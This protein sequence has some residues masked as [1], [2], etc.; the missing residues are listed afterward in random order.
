MKGEAQAVGPVKPMPPHG[1]HCGTVPLGGEVGWTTT[2]EE[3]GPPGTLA[4]LEGAGDELPVL[5]NVEPMS[6]HLMF[7]KTTLAFG[8]CDSTWA[9]TPEVVGQV[10]RATP[11]R[12]GSLSVG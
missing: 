7:E 9:G 1:P 5:L 6:P 12:D 3:D 2:L 4:E 8:L 10:P 11:G